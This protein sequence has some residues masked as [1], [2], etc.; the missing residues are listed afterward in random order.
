MSDQQ[1]YEEGARFFWIHNTGPIGCLPYS[2]I[3]DRSKPRNLDKIGCVAPQNKVAREFNK[4]LKDIVLKLRKQLPEAALT[5]VDVYSAKYEL[6]SKAKNLGKE[7]FVPLS[8]LVS[9][10][11]H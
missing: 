10:M 9:G 7:R 4:Q 3:Y 5:Y 8:I 1:L 11:T 6:I 2:I